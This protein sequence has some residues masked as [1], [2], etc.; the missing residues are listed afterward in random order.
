[1]DVLKASAKLQQQL[2]AVRNS[3]E[4]IKK[5]TPAQLVPPAPES[6]PVGLTKPASKPIW[7]F[8]LIGVLLL[9]ALAFFFTR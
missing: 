5:A 4:N 2:A 8:V 3:R 7:L 9:G 6:E 1:M